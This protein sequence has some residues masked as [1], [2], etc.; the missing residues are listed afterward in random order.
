[1]FASTTG[2]PEHN[3]RFRTSDR[4]SRAATRNLPSTRRS[5]NDGQSFILRITEACNKSDRYDS[6]PLHQW[7]DERHILL[8]RNAPAELIGPQGW[9]VQ[10]YENLLSVSDVNSFFPKANLLTL[11]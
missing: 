10:L 7:D 9:V 8:I 1:M 6:T 3:E 11:G 2:L 5:W 4:D